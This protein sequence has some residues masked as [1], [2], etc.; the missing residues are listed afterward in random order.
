MAA[1]VADA[2]VAD[3]TFIGGIGVG[4]GT[5]ERRTQRHGSNGLVLAVSHSGI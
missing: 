3:T 4:T 5:A 1:T 2:A